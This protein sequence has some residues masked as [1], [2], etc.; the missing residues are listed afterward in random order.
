MELQMAQTL[1]DFI[2]LEIE[3]RGMSAR[4][5]AELIDVSHTTINR[6][7]NYGIT[8]EYNGKPVGEPRLD[9]LVK[10]ARATGVDIR[11][12]VS[13]VVPKEILDDDVEAR[14]L[15]EQIKQLP[16]EARQVLDRYILGTRLH[17]EPKNDDS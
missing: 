11:T 6:F 3:R 5:F 12:I 7:L 9:F 15:A 8:N 14:I 17:P 4:E 16:L 10:L 13:L 2:L 1:G